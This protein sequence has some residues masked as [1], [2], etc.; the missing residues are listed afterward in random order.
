MKFFP[1]QNF[2]LALNLQKQASVNII[3]EAENEDMSPFLP[4]KFPHCITANKP[5]LYLGPSESEVIRLLGPE[6]KYSVKLDDVNE[7]K[8]LIVELN[9]KS[10]NV[11]NVPELIDVVVLWKRGKRAIDTRKKQLGPTISKANFK[12]KFEMKTNMDFDQI[13]NKFIRKSSVLGLY[14]AKNTSIS[15][16]ETDFDLSKY[17]NM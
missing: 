1:S 17:A 3:I 13:A 9:I 11:Q 8:T 5:V 15:L 10:A 16:G 12:D 4:A 2:D 7:I 14:H 6:Y